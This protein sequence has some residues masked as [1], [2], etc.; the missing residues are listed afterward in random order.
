MP[1]RKNYNNSPSSSTPLP[2]N[3]QNVPPCPHLPPPPNATSRPRKRKA[4]HSLTGYTFDKACA[5][6]ASSSPY[7]TYIPSI[8]RPAAVPYPM[9]TLSG[10]AKGA[11]EEDLERHLLN[12]LGKRR[13]RMEGEDVMLTPGNSTVTLKAADQ[14]QKKE[15]CGGGLDGTSTGVGGEKYKGFED[16]TGVLELRSA[17][18]VLADAKG[19]G[20]GKAEISTASEDEGWMS[21]ELLDEYDMLD[22]VFDASEDEDYDIVKNEPQAEYNGIAPGRKKAG[23]MKQKLF[24]GRKDWMG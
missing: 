16:I 22:D 14:E 4:D 21:D 24:G 23:W 19:N 7:G 12:R 8:S 9:S 13:I 20:K 6:V 3:P 11:F 10:S 18:P 1:S 5:S 2:T 17:R 15:S